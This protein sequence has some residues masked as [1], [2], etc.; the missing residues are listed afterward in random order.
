MYFGWNSFTGAFIS[1][2]SNS[3]QRV[4]DYMIVENLVC[5]LDMS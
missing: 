2:N 4:R 5:Q 1:K 3:I